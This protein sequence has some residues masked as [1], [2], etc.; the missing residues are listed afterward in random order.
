[1]DITEETW[2]R[3]LGINLEGTVNM[4][5]AFVL[6]V[7]DDKTPRAVVNISSGAGVSGVANRLPYVASKWAICGITKGMAPELG[8]FGIRVNCVAPGVTN[9]PLMSYFFNDPDTVARSI[10][11]HPIGR[12]GEAEEVAAV[13]LFLLTDDASYMT[14]AIVPVDGGET[15]IL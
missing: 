13:I 3:V 12:L 5:Q 7:K 11:R 4:T 15:A 9:T 10:A 8:P 1:L 6:A 14:G 2:D